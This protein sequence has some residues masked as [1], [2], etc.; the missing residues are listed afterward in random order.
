MTPITRS[1]SSWTAFVVHSCQSCPSTHVMNISTSK[2]TDTS[3]FIPVVEHDVVSN[4]PTQ[5][6]CRLR[7]APVKPEQLMDWWQQL[8]ID[9]V[10]VV[11]G[12]LT[13]K[14]ILLLSATCK[15]LRAV[16]T[17]RQVWDCHHQQHPCR[18]KTWEGQTAMQRTAQYMRFAVMDYRT[19]QHRITRQPDHRGGI[20]PS[21]FELTNNGGLPLEDVGI[22]APVP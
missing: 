17:A 18:Y 7:F 22:H 21:L 13:P 16:C 19:M 8:P 4:S 2:S 1:T 12:E 20:F 9:I 3:I 5:A 10:G 6:L 11:C 15:R 14:E